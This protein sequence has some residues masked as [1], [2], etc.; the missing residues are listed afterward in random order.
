MKK[1]ERRVIGWISG[2]L[3]LLSSL[4]AQAQGPLP[5]SDTGALAGTNGSN[6]VG[7]G[8]FV[9]MVFA[10]QGDIFYVR[11]VPGEDWE[12]AIRVNQT[13][14][15]CRRPTVSVAAKTVSV[16]FLCGQTNYND[17]YYTTRFNFR[18]SVPVSFK[19]ET[20]LAT[21]ATEPAMISRDGDVH[22]VWAE[23]FGVAYL[24]FPATGDPSQS[25]IEYVFNS[26]ICV[27]QKLAN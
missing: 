9:H 10:E 11:A 4:G 21:S 7:D 24:T 18:T 14:T 12:P 13:Q 5:V 1:R 8:E 25:L 16:V 20:L 27:S 23:P 17:L 6:I 3:F 2:A 26:P 19:P 22:I 15:G